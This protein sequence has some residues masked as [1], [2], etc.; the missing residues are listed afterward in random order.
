MSVQG[1]VSLSF[2]WTLTC[3]AVTHLLVTFSTAWG[4]VFLTSDQFCPKSALCK[5]KGKRWTGRPGPPT[6]ATLDVVEAFGNH[7]LC[8][9]APLE[10]EPQLAHGSA[11]RLE[12]SL[13]LLKRQ[14]PYGQSGNDYANYTVPI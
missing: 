14:F 8:L 7:E 9:Q 6:G 5:S 10:S 4:V 11:G 13:H 12:G 2:L 3:T 1:S